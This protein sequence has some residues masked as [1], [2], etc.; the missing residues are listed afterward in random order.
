[1]NRARLLIALC[2]LAFTASAQYTPPPA[3]AGIGTVTSVSGSGP[4]WLTWTI[5]T[6]TSTPA[7]S[8]APTTAQSSHQVIGTCGATTTFAPCAL[9]ATDLPA[10]SLAFSSYYATSGGNY[11]IGP[12]MRQATLPVVGNFSFLS[13]QGGATFAADGDAALFTVPFNASDQI[14]AAGFNMGANTQITVAFSCSMLILDFR[15]CGV[16]LKESSTGK[17]YFCGVDA[18]STSG[19]VSFRTVKWSNQTT[20]TGSFTGAFMGF[21]PVYWL[22][23][24]QTGGNV[25]CSHSEDG[26]AG[27]FVQLESLA[28]TNPFTTAADQ[29]GVA[30]RL[31][32]ASGPSIFMVV[33][34][35]AVQ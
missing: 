5:G 35:V 33:Y 32:A 10:G 6:P 19:G 27:H 31:T 3:G 25:S 8:L 13:T 2:A 24:S 7:I 15:Q 1:M 9:A 22:Q 17:Y 16:F 30:G 12:N 26:S 23:L 18:R 29:W 14:R 20:Q 11:Y 4:S 21:M 28:Q 34:S